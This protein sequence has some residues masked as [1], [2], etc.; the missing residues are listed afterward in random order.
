[1]KEFVSAVK[2]I[3]EPQS[4]PRNVFY[5]SLGNERFEFEA[6]VIEVETTT[7]DMSFAILADVEASCRTI[8]ADVSEMAGKVLPGTVYRFSGFINSRKPKYEQS[9]ELIFRAVEAK[10]LHSADERRQ[11][12]VDSLPPP[13]KISSQPES[14]HLVTSEGSKEAADFKKTV[15]GKIPV[16]EF[17][18]TGGDGLL[19]ERIAAALHRAAKNADVVVI[20][21][22][23]GS[24]RSL[25]V[26][27]EKKVVRSVAEVAAKVPVITGIGHE[28]DNLWVDRVVTEN[29]R[30]PTAAAE[31]LLRLRG[32]K[33]K[34]NRDGR[35]QRDHQTDLDRARIGFE[36]KLS[37]RERLCLRKGILLGFLGG[38]SASLLLY[39][40]V[41]FFSHGSICK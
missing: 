14:V 9:L 3:L 20:V 38:A 40:A 17:F 27:N 28:G 33:L 29:A 4:E 36:A 6:E 15:E 23:G 8:C 13:K 1:M 41:R 12:F 37:K 22:G 7:T 25:H 18:W 35:T 32:Q 2:K 11:K 16:R 30:T 21:R 5:R 26:F 39:M 31:I 10:E 19:T 34:A 24:R